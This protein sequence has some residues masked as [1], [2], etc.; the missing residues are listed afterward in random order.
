MSPLEREELRN[1][2]AAH[3]ETDDPTRRSRLCEQTIHRCNGILFQHIQN[4]VLRFEAQPYAR[5]HTVTAQQFH[6][7]SSIVTVPLVTWMH[8]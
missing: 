1:L 2:D 7:W 5:C 3:Q 4:R 6:V 8:L